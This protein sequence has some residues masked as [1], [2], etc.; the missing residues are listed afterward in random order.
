MSVEPCQSGHPCRAAGPMTGM[1]LPRAVGGGG[2]GLGSET[3]ERLW[4][5]DAAARWS[6]VGK[7]MVAAAVHYRRGASD[8]GFR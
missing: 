6:G 1:L 7:E 5:G 8:K 3:A 2:R 4:R